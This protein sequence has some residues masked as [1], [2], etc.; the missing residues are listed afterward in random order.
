MEGEL[1]A[2]TN[3][4]ADVLTDPNFFAI[5]SILVLCG[6]VDENTIAAFDACI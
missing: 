6:I 3:E 4:E 1:N 5:R 2:E